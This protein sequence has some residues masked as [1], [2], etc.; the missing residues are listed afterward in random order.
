MA[1]VK[2]SAAAAAAAAASTESTVTTAAKSNTATTATTESNTATNTTAAIAAAP[3][4]TVSA[5][6]EISV[7]HCPCLV[8]QR[9]LSLLLATKGLLLA[10]D[11]FL[12]LNKLEFGT[13]LSLQLRFD[14]HSLLPLLC[15]E[16]M[17]LVLSGN[18]LPPPLL[19]L[20]L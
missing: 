11:R 12:L 1:V 5:S 20:D 10:D 6:T 2:S 9:V 8:S 16:L 18:L 13:P 15:L 4:A 19:V 3:T 17:E 7:Q 14:P